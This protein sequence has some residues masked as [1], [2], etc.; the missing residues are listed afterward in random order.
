MEYAKQ[1]PDCTVAE[2]FGC[3]EG[4]CVVLINNDFGE[5]KCPFFKTNQQVEEEKAYCEERLEKILTK[6][7]GE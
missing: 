5:R 1:I 2:C 7:K 4:K 3:E 6:N